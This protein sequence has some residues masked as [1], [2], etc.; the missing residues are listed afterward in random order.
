MSPSGDIILF[1]VC[2]P[3]REASVA[4]GAKDVS[5]LR[6]AGARMQ[7]WERVLEYLE[8]EPG[9]S[10]RMVGIA[11]G[12]N[13][14][15]ASYHLRKL[16][17]AGRVTRVVNGRE[18]VW[19]RATSSLC[20]VLRRAMPLMRRAQVPVV[21]ARLKETPRTARAVA[22]EAGLPDGTVRWAIDLLCEAGIAQKS[23]VGHPRLRDGAEVCVARALAGET[24]PMW[25]ACAPSRRGDEPFRDLRPTSFRL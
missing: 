24:C 13:S 14:S 21:A 5:S 1:R 18:V 12:I 9:Q 3:H 11:M 15:T 23:G 25:G 10:V 8:R 20:P 19:F 16:E 2:S 17:R 7:M 4:S 22:R 6:H